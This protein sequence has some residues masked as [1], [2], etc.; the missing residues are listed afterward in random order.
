[1]AKNI[2][3]ER[4][5][6]ENGREQSRYVFSHCDH[7]RQRFWK[8]MPW[9][10]FCST[11]C[12]VLAAYHQRRRTPMPLSRTRLLDV[13]FTY[14]LLSRETG[15]LLATTYENTTWADPAN[16]PARQTSAS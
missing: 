3:R 5:K 6:D 13:H 9:G 1:M 11:K 8:K 4:Y 12:R 15:E 7:C 16:E 14:F 10:R 2:W